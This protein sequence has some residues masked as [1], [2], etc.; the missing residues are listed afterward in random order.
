MSFVMTVQ[1]LKDVAAFL[2]GL[3]K[4]SAETGVQI[5]H[6]DAVQITTSE[7]VAVSFSWKDNEYGIRQYVLEERCS[8]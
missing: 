4:L 7:A 2:E 3:A 8:P 6:Y 1:E 5:A